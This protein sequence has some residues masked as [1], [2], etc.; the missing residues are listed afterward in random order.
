MGFLLVNAPDRQCIALTASRQRRMIEMNKSPQ[1][2][3]SEAKV[4]NQYSDVFCKK[5]LPPYK[6][7]DSPYMTI[8]PNEKR[9]LKG[10]PGKPNWK[11]GGSSRPI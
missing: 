10:P 1:Q 4:R 11:P 7:V 9:G 3:M 2:M 5:P 8:D 6:F